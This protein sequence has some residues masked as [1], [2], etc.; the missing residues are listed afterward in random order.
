MTRRSFLSLSSSIALLVGLF[1][2]CFPAALLASKGA[3]LS[4]AAMVWVRE[5]GV[6]LIPL[7]LMGLLVRGHP[8]SPTMRAFLLGNALIQLG[9]FPVEIAAYHAGVVT[10]LAGIVPNSVLHVLLAAG[11]GWFWARSRGGSALEAHPREARERSH[12]L[13]E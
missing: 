2:L 9:L 13:T 5:V 10:S 1:A 6:L 3:A 4:P 7:G 8:D 11:F 12:A